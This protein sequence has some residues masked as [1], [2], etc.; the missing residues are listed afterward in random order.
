LKQVWRC[1]V[2]LGV[3]EMFVE[4]DCLRVVGQTIGNESRTTMKKLLLLPLLA[5]ILSTL[6]ASAPANARSEGPQLSPMQKG[7]PTPVPPKPIGPPK[8]DDE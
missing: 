2:G 4:V 6:M 1:F 5:V 3:A 8:S 7:K